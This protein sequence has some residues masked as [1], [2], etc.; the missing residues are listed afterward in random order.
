MRLNRVAEVRSE[1]LLT[2][3]LTAQGWDVRKP[4]SGDLLRQQEYK[5]HSALLDAFKGRSKSGGSGYGL[6]EAILVDRALQPIAVLE[7]KASVKDLDL[8]IADLT[9]V[10]GPACIDAGFFP[11]LI[12]IAGTSEDMFDVRVFKWSG[13][14]WKP[15]TYEGN[16]IGWI[17]NRADTELLLAPSVSPELR[18]SVP[19]PEVLAARAD[20]INRLLREAKIKDEF[21]PGIVA[22]AMLG[23]WQSK[24]KIRKEPEHILHDLND[25]CEK[26][27]WQA[28]KPELAKSLHIDEANN[29]LAEKARRIVTILERLNVTVLTAE[30]DYLG[31]LYETFFRYTGGNTIGQ[32]FTPRHITAF[33]ADL[34]E[35]M[36]NDIV[37]DPACGTG[38]FLISAM[39]RMQ[40]VGKL[41]REETIKRVQKQ[42][43]GFDSEPQTAALCVAN[44]ILRGDGKTGVH[45]GNCFSDKEY[46]E[47]KANVV[48][49]NPPFP[50]KKTDTPSEAFVDRAFDGLQTRGL[51]ATI[52]PQSL[53]VK[54]DK[55]RWRE[56]V[57]KNN[58]LEAVIL[59]PDEIFQPYAST[60]T[61]V[62]VVRKGVAHRM[63]HA[64]F[65]AR[66]ENDGFRMK[67]GVR[68]KQEGD[69]IP[70]L[71]EAFHD[72][73]SVAGVCGWAK[74]DAVSG[75]APGA[76]IQAQPMTDEAIEAGA[77][78]LVRNRTA[79]VALHAHELLKISQ[80]GTRPYWKMKGRPEPGEPDSK[81][82]GGYFEIY[83][84]QKVLHNKEALLP[85][86]ALI[87]SSSGVDNGCYG[88][89]DFDSLIAPP[90]VTVPSTGSIAE[91]H[92]QEW[93]CGVTDDCLIL[94]PKREVP[95]EVLYIAAAVIRGEKW[96]FSY[97]RKATP[98]RISK[99][100]LPLSQNTIDRIRVYLKRAM[101]IEKSMMKNAEDTIDEDIARQ[102]I[103]EIKRQPEKL[104]GGEPLVKK[105]AELE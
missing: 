38:G 23:L 73:K 51:L 41:S 71:T 24:G 88:F 83:Y 52:L 17:P 92:V 57:L 20:E 7:V 75:F 13:R 94:V 45:Q 42:L 31:Q 105:L 27:F 37:L 78:E 64:V 67:K 22:A 32:F 25:A 21:R 86:P 84:G 46:P 43:I 53:L 81:T 85:G 68:I 74:Y 6:P 97:G 55:A 87:V 93:A 80:E 103:S 66:I 5:D 44:M 62:V 4:P 90:F 77:L 18:P 60:N 99:F 9:G 33:M 65:F 15:V 100:P 96:R 29:L 49:M 26:A 104:I 63:N 76:Y 19:P 16:P 14:K 30:H 12:A 79:F 3:L 50:H 102:R 91:A 54:K 89:F 95:K 98:E 40:V 56:R 1:V 72:H 11:L 2:E 47:G 34:C 39:N 8:A 58:T 59:L 35:V 48:L 10:Y 101:A 70:R 61:A 82:I 28:K 69:Q 36:P